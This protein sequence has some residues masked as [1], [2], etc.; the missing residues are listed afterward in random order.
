LAFVDVTW[1]D[2]LD[3]FGLGD[4]RT[5]TPGAGLVNLFELSLE[6]AA[7]LD[8][9]QAPSFT[10]ATLRFDTLGPG[11]TPLGLTI[12]ALGDAQGDPLAAIGI[13]GVVRVTPADTTTV[14]EPSTCLLLATG[15][16]FAFRRRAKTR[17]SM[18]SQRASSGHSVVER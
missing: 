2:Q 5:L 6:A 1:G 15:I 8:A 14:P 11:L 12:N 17:R 9:L 3:L 18:R 13:G 16:G 7:D 4:V 10:V